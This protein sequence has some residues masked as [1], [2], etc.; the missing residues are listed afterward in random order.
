MWKFIGE[1]VLF[2]V[3]AVALILFIA[4]FSL[5]KYQDKE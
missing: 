2:W 3:F 4:S 1:E 5:K